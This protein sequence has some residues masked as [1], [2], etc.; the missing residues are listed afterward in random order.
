MS[1]F[2]KL[3]DS[4]SGKTEAVTQKFKEGLTKTRDMLAGRGEDLFFR[5]K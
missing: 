4:I 2:K 5:W 1:F 3:R